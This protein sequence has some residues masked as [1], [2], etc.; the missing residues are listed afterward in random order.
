MNEGVVSETKNPGE[1]CLVFWL[2]DREFAIRAGS[3]QSVERLTPIT[4][5]P[6]SISWI[7]GVMNLRGSIVSVVDLREFLHLEP[8]KLN[9]RTRLLALQQQEM[10][11][12]FIVD[13]VQEMLAVSPESI[14]SGR[15]G[16]AAVPQWMLP[17]A[18]SSILLQERMIVLLDVERL[19]F[20]DKIQRF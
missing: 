2:Q 6:N 5:V 11:I 20:S 10:V 15:A 17:Y 3:V 19:L 13:A 4:P 12:S 8:A 9:A 14:V 7:K 18:S 16:Q 1:Q